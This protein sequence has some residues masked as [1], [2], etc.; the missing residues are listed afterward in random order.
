M[1]A[2]PNSCIFLEF[3][4]TNQDS[5][6]IVQEMFNLWWIYQ[7]NYILSTLKLTYI[8]AILIFFSNYLLVCAFRIL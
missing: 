2:T 6:N 3:I 5:S 1:I 8:A 7:V 4:Y